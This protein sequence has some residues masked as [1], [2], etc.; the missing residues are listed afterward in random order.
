VHVV[1]WGKERV[2]TVSWET[3]R[4]RFI[5]RGR[6]TRD[7]IALERD[8]ILTGGEG[9]VLD[10][11]FAIRTRV[12]LPP[13]QSASVAFTTL[14]AESRERAFALADRY[15]DPHAAQRAFDLAWTASQVELRELDLSPAAAAVCQE[16]AGH[17]LYGHPGLRA[18]QSDLRRNHGAQPLLWEFGVSGDL[19]ILLATINSTDG[20]PTLR[21]LLAA[22]RFWRRRGMAV[23]LVILDEH[24]H[25]YLQVLGD[26]IAAVVHAVNEADALDRPGGVYVRRRELLSH[27]SDLMLRATARLHVL[28]DGRSLGRI[29][30]TAIATASP[31]VPDLRPVHALRDPR[32]GGVDDREVSRAIARQY[33]NGHGALTA[34]GDYEIGVRGD[35]VPPAPWANVIANP[36]GGFVITERG[37]GFTWAANSYFFRLSPWHN[38]PVCDPVSDVVYLHDERTGDTWCAT[39]API[40]TDTAYTVTHTAGKT[41]FQHQ[42]HGLAV[43]Y[44]VGMADGSAVKVGLLRITNTGDTPRRIVVTT[45]VEWVLGVSRELCQH[46]VRTWFDRDRRAI[47]AQNSFDA[48]FAP[49][50]AFH[51]IT[52]PVIEHTGSRRTFLGRHGTVAA[53]AGM[54]EGAILSSVTG[55]GL[56][57]CAALRC[58]IELAPGAS[59]EIGTLLGAA[60]DDLSAQDTLAVL[61]SVDAVRGAL[62]GSTAAWEH[63]LTTVTV[64]TPDPLFDAMINRW[65]LYQALSC[66][67]WGRSA[68]YQS[69]GAYGFRDQL[70]DVMAFVYTDPALTREHI[71]RAASRQ[72]VE[73][74]V[75][76][77]WHPHTGC[78]VRTRFADDLVWLPYVVDFYIRVT[79]DV[80]ILDQYV[81]FITMRALGP[82]EHEVY[83][84]PTV[85]DEHASLY[86]HCLRAL[87]RAA[88]T[89]VH[90]LPLIGGGDWNDGMNRVGTGGQGESVWLAWFL[91]ATQCAFA[92]HAAARGDATVATT[93]RAQAQAY[94]D[95]VET[96]GWDGQW[97]RRA[98][99]DDGSSLGSHKNS[100]CRIDSI[101]QSWSVISGAASEARQAEA[102]ASHEEYL[103]RD[104]ERMLLLLTPPFD[105]TTRDPGYIKGYVPGVRENGAQYTHAALWAVWA[106]SLRGDGERAFEL[107]QMINPLTH[108]RSSAEVAVYQVE[109][110]VVAADVY[111]AAGRVGRGGWT[112]YTGSASWMYRV[113]LEGILGFDLRGD[114]LVI[115]PRA[116]ASWRE[117]AITYRFG[118]T[119]YDITVRSDGVGARGEPRISIDGTMITGA[120]IPLVDDGVRRTVIVVHGAPTP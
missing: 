107:F 15:R 5:G 28:C 100:E 104:A 14:V 42:R 117:Y 21:A 114:R 58:V 33:H 25:T 35:M 78:G 83:D 18:S 34:R 68:L 113:G 118:R 61:G 52:E 13:G 112:W 63:R 17:L 84:L 7:P 85:T 8:G 92:E 59:H 91:I 37:G 105:D 97:Y 27:E 98:F 9:A 99:Y 69:S 36:H 72:F 30:A 48:G 95:A 106:T 81:P 96:H 66:R 88:T 73:G 47:W 39:P 43:Q 65:S 29:L 19:P 45:Y 108:A 86:E 44:A 101:A 10:P 46:Q 53:P 54:R 51:A 93:L 23:D 70:Q 4:S 38:D 41:T 31:S 56:D 90:G 103:V 3:D 120:A 71:L 40:R 67:M 24:A 109:P 22:H 20:L 80:T 55:A 89:G 26:R 2:G 16:L 49:W 57:P 87:R 76:H 1:D 6:S 64:R 62:Q 12:L 75:Q 11:I 32:V 111:T 82:D 79:G 77:W 119:E 60:E 116:P 115:A 102:M 50:Q 74:D 94:R 110:Y